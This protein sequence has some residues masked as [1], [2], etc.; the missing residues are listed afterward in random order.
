MAVTAALNA[1][2][3]FFSK[4]GDDLRSLAASPRE[5][6]IVYVVKFLESLGYFAIY[7]L[8]SVYLREDLRYGDVRAGAIFGT[9]VTS[10]TVMTFFAGFVADRLGIRRALLM[11]VASCVAGRALLLLGDRTL[12][13]TGLGVMSWGVASM[14]PTLATALRQYTRRE[15]IPFAFSLYYVMMNVGALVAPLTIGY[16]RRRFSHGVDLTLPLVGAKH[17]TS[18]QA[19]FGVAVVSTVLAAMLVFTLRSDREVEALTAG[20]HGETEP[21]P[22]KAIKPAPWKAFV[23]LLG[24]KDFW[25]FML[26]V[27]LLVFVKLIFQHA[28]Q[29]WPIYT[30]REFGRDFNFGFIWSINPAMIIV[31]TPVV[32]A[33][34]R[35]RS[36]FVCI[37]AGSLITAA[38]VFFMAASTTVAA[39]VA[40][41]VLL[42]IGEALWSP[43]LYEYTAMIAPRGKE[44]TYM[45]L[46]SL[47]MF[48]AK[49]VVG[50]MS[51]WMLAKWCP[52][53]GPRQS[54]L[55]WLVIGMLTLAGPMAILALRRVIEPPVKA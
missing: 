28:H 15:A 1:E 32:T 8:A 33:L 12:A 2:K 4:L 49:M 30:I 43:R 27:T 38:S 48:L 54:Q 53:T 52:E 46:S 37:V 26:F 47:P 21:Q 13:L 19:V 10:I 11:S 3:G 34:T 22:E 24:D 14:L 25:R 9:W 23:E 17:W 55:M 20:F 44:A 41:V 7:N 5:L 45:G 50:G 16:F 40:F 35:Q 42:S 6:W 29:T 36:A 51:G 39:S 31:L 18:S